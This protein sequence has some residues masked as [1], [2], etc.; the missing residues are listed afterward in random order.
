M[1]YILNDAWVRTNGVKFNVNTFS[2]A[3]SG[4]YP[5]FNLSFCGSDN[6]WFHLAIFYN[7]NKSGRALRF[8]RELNDTNIW[9]LY[10]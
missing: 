6:S 9:V 8:W 2:A 10:K 1:E 4:D 7:T 3:D 5:G